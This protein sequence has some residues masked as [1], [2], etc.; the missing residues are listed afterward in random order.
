MREFEK[1]AHVT[2]FSFGF[3]CLLAAGCLHA[4]LAAQPSAT[5]DIEHKGTIIVLRDV[6][7][8]NALHRPAQAEPL[9]VRTGPDAI[10]LASVARGLEPLTNDQQASI[11][12]STQES[13]VARTFSSLGDL[14]NTETALGAGISQQ[15][16][17][18]SSGA[19]SSAIAQI[20]SVGAIVRN[21][22][23]GGQ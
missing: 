17:G 3:A 20:P 2:S 22:T 13:V 11:F 12:G 15:R 6:P 23:G 16:G 7:Y 4:P 9:R 14:R 5:D 18:G 19:I 10:I 8:G 1:S 21:A